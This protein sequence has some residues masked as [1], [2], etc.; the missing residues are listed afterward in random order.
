MS[1][2]WCSHCVTSNYRAIICLFKW[3]CNMK[4]EK[5]KYGK[6]RVRKMVNGVSVCITYDHK[7][8][9][10]E[11]EKDL[12]GKSMLQTANHELTFE[13]A[14]LQYISIKDKVLSPATINGYKSVLRNL[15]DRFK[16]LKIDK[17]DNLSIQR[18]IN[19]YSQNRSPKTVRNASGLITVVMGMYSPDLKINVKLPQKI[20]TKSY[21]PTD[22]DVKRIL[23][24]AKGSN[25]E[26]VL[27]LAVYGLRKSELLCIDKNSIDGNILSIESAKVTNGRAYVT[28]TTKTTSSTRQIYIDDVLAGQISQMEQPFAMYPN[29]ILRYLHR[30]QDRLEIPRFRL[31]DLRHYYVSMAHQLG[32]PDAIIAQT[33]GHVNTNTTRAI[34]LHAMQDKVVEEQKNASNLLSSLMS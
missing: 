11:I 22:D 13:Q 6:Y 31:H 3:W 9:Q 12:S 33:V 4:I 18:E 28:K 30:V 8:T 23:E 19:E 26:I 24:Y 20:K 25:Y 29:D 14:V 34:Y 2:L 17:I 15:S 27:K 32:V 21:F 10:K 7:P 1:V 16:A 5:T